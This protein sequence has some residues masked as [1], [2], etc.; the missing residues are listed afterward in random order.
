MPEP[1]SLHQPGVRQSVLGGGPMRRERQVSSA[2][3]APR[4]NNGLCV[5][6]RVSG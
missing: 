1:D 4:Q 5:H 3:H 2:R 6:Y